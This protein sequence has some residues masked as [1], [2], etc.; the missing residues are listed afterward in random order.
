MARRSTLQ[1]S[2]QAMLYNFWLNE[3]LASQAIEEYTLWVASPWVNN[4]RLPVP[5]HVSLAEVVAR[6][7]DTLQIFDILAQI[8]VNGGKVRIVVGDDVE[9][10]PPLRELAERHR[11]I[12]VRVLP[13]L[14]AKVYAGHYGALD[15]SLNLTGSGVGRNAELYTYYSDERGIAEL[16]E[17]CRTLFE[18]GVVL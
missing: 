14:H 18:R 11:R 16:T 7:G 8:A 4:F 6:R 17:H 3:V 9:Q 15:G 10:H 1:L 2:G 5:Y 13:R 12:Q